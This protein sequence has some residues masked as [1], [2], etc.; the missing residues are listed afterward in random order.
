MKYWRMKQNSKSN[1]IYFSTKTESKRHYLKKSEVC[2]FLKLLKE[3]FFTE[4]RLNRCSRA[5][6]FLPDKELAIE[7]LDSEKESNLEV[8]A[9]KYGCRVVGVS[10]LQDL[11][12][13]FVEKL[14][15]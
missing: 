4:A 5:D 7:V 3:P 12:L 14:I 1:V 11:S 8:K 6:V 10:C 13:G 15:N 9:R 2:Y